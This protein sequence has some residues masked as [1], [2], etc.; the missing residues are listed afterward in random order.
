M[1]NDF[2]IVLYFSAFFESV[3]DWHTAN[4]YAEKARVLVAVNY[5]TNKKFEIEHDSTYPVDKIDLDDSAELAELDILNVD[6]SSQSVGIQSNI[7]QNRDNDDDD[8]QTNELSTDV[9]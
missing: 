4:A 8:S 9:S 5:A 1:E 7:G 6:A 3:D 2:W